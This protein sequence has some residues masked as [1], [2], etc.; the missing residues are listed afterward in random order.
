[1]HGALHWGS[2]FPTPSPISIASN[3]CDEPFSCWPDG[4]SAGHSASRDECHRSCLDQSGARRWLAPPLRQDDLCTSAASCR[5]SDHGL[6]ARAKRHRALR[7]RN[8]N[9]RGLRPRPAVCTAEGRRMARHWISEG[10]FARSHRKFSLVQTF[11]CRMKRGG[12]SA[13]VPAG[14]LLERRLLSP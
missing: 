4:V 12:T 7:R 6:L 13:V 8:I 5:C 14:I 1:M 2:P 11:V 3:R 10:A 9:D